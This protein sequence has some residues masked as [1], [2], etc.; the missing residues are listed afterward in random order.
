VSTAATPRRALL[1]ATLAAALPPPARALAVAGTL[2]LD[3]RRI[4]FGGLS[5]LWIG[6]APAGAPLP[7]AAVSDTGAWLTASL[8]L[9][10]ALRP[11]GLALQRT[12]RLADEHG[13]PLPRGELSDAEALARLPDGR[14]LVAFERWH[15][16]RLYETL[17][18]PARH[19]HPPPG[20]AEA[21]RN[22]GIEALAVLPD[23]GLLAIAES[24]PA[25]PGLRRAWLGRTAPRG[26]AWQ[27]LAYRPAEGLEPT[28]A[29]ALPDGR[30]L[31][32]ERGFTLLGGFFGR[33]ALLPGAAAPVLEGPTMLAFPGALP[34][35]NWECVAVARA[36]AR[37]VAAFVSDDNEHPLQRSL[38]AVAA[39]G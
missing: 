33:V 9:D 1:A 37:L 22:G 39:L 17:D 10:A 26:I 27:R 11:I 21:P 34:A 2:E 7:L 14:F 12:G 20:L 30:V 8:R 28:G 6:D 23:G 36:G 35:E 29:A 16:I 4:G 15:R 31:V 25:G 5:G 19:L 3:T 13:R 38:L 32:V 24:L 18:G